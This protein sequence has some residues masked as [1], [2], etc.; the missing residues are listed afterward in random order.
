MQKNRNTRE[1]AALESRAVLGI[2]DSHNLPTETS[3]PKSAAA[4]DTESSELRTD[5]PCTQMLHQLFNIYDSLVVLK[6]TH[7]TSHASKEVDLRN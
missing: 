7:T 2:A 6:S 1:I 3:Q 5:K 4:L